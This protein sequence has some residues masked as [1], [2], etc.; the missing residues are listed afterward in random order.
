MIKPSSS[1]ILLPAISRSSTSLASSLALEGSGARAYWRLV[2]EELV[3]AVRVAW[4]S[5]LCWLRSLERVPR[6]AAVHESVK[7]VWAARVRSAAGFIN[8]VLRRAT[9]EPDYDPAE[10]AD[11]VEKLAIE[12]SHP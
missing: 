4:R 10:V 7:L 9:R 2:I 5:G 12:T 3:W 1:P 11:P 6:S 8:A